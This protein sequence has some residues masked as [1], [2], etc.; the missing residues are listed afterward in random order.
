MSQKRDYY[1]VLGVSRQADEATIKRAYRKLAKKYHPDTNAGNK[2]A[3][4]KFKEISEAYSVLSD[5][6]K[7]KLY[8]QFG[9]AAFEQG[10]EPGGGYSGGFSGF[11]GSPF[12]SGFSGGQTFHFEG[13]NMDDFMNDIFG[14]F[15]HGGSRTSGQ[16][17]D[18]FGGAR[19]QTKGE[20]IETT[21]SIT[22]EEAAFGCDKRLRLSSEGRPG[23]SAIEV[24]I[25]A[26]INQGQSVRLKGKGQRNPYGAD[27]DLLIKV[28]ILDKKG[29]ERKGQDVYTTVTIPYTT[30]VLG[31]ETKVHTLYGDVL[32]NIKE[33]TQSGTKIRL[34]GKGIERMNHPN[35]H[36]DQYAVIQIDVPSHISSKAREKLREY[37]Q[38][39]G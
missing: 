31:G 12:G 29:Y 5:K 30:A 4:Q 2:E 24:H 25:P 35:E 1:D 20:D 23:S 3:E 26:G 8:D 9:H 32:L 13:G 16:R 33:G 27:G 14:G 17:S 22:F 36:G 28:N 18:P 11:G 19:Q 39:I 38:M 34:R 7:K 21:I 37:Q 6:E 15:F 10:G